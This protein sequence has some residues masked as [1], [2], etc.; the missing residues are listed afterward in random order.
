MAS[1]SFGDIEWP[2]LLWCAIMLGV[3]PLGLALVLLLALLRWVLVVLSCGRLRWGADRTRVLKQTVWRQKEPR[4]EHI[5]VVLMYGY[6]H[7]RQT[8]DPIIR[9]IEEDKG[10]T[11]SSGGQQ[12]SAHVDVDILV[13]GLPA[14]PLDSIL[15]TNWFGPCGVFS[16]THPDTILEAM[17]REVVKAVDKGE[18]TKLVLVGHSIGAV[19]VRNLY[20]KLHDDDGSSRART[21][22]GEKSELAANGAPHSD[23][24]ARPPLDVRLVLLSGTNRGFA[25]GNGVRSLSSN[26]VLNAILAGLLPYTRI[27]VGLIETLARRPVFFISH[28]R[29]GSVYICK[30]RLK[31]LEMARP[32]VKRTR[33]SPDSPRPPRPEKPT[34]PPPFVVQLAGSNDNAASP[35]DDIDLLVLD[36]ERPGPASEDRFVY[37][38]ILGSDHES[39][40]DVS[41]ADKKF[42]KVRREAVL[43][44]LFEPPETLVALDETK[45]IASTEELSNRSKLRQNVEK[46]KHVVFVLH[47][48]RDYGFWTSKL[49]RS[50]QKSVWDAEKNKSTSEELDQKWHFRAMG[51]A[52]GYFGALPFLL[53]WDRQTKVEWFM[54]E[55]VTARAEFP[56]AD[57]HFVGHSNATYIAARALAEYDCCEFERVVFAGSVVET[58]YPWEKVLETQPGHQKPQVGCV[59]NYVATAD[60]IVATF[61]KAFERLCGCFG[62]G[63]G[64]G[65]S[66]GFSDLTDRLLEAGESALH[67]KDEPGG[68]PAFP[69]GS[70]YQV[71]YIVGGHGAGVQD[72]N[73]RAIANFVTGTTAADPK[74][75]SPGPTALLVE[76]QGLGFRVWN[77]GIGIVVTWT[78]LAAVAAAPIGISIWRMVVTGELVWLWTSLIW[79]WVIT[80]FQVATRF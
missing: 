12:G 72:I 73:W 32:D 79:S 49:A 46:G 64:G 43:S 36:A 55:Y 58:T 48:I 42:G 13:P 27:L 77:C 59:L 5:L 38:T 28:F 63:L 80:V 53:A 45:L 14:T 1:Q 40:L 19:L 23:S 52:Y 68:N 39:V 74:T 60:W 17:H 30:S 33:G 44:A 10:Q 25:F 24:A 66:D 62:L 65:G 37:R 50:I 75:E 3:F 22:C 9:A 78:A 18:Y 51:T 16:V 41:D 47:G 26:L 71:K 57:F 67:P 6:S 15:G 29:R 8:L 7:T 35:Q 2:P 21:F 4:Q 56:H 61:P 11:R 54:D 20:L 31:W 76:K 34:R 69:D 70:S